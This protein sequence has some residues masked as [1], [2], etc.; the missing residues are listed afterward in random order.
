MQNRSGHLQPYPGSAGT[1]A[2]VLQLPVD[3]SDQSPAALASRRAARKLLIRFAPDIDNPHNISVYACRGGK[4]LT[5][6]RLT[7]YVVSC[8]HVPIWLP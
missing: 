5:W 1:P 3:L 4:V 2:I 7:W 8:P 6:E